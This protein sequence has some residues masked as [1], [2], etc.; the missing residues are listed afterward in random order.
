MHWISSGLFQPQ[1]GSYKVMQ[2][3]TFLDSDVQK[4]CFFPSIK[5]SILLTSSLL[6]TSIS[7]LFSKL[8]KTTTN[9]PLVIVPSAEVTTSLEI[10][11]IHFSFPSKSQTPPIASA[12]SI[13]LVLIASVTISLY[14]SKIFV[15]NPLVASWSRSI[16]L[17]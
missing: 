7:N 12:L 14:F 16:I 10:S 5:S 4:V 9:P 17:L 11:S 3:S 15:L 2:K 6:L 1:T 13:S 8:F